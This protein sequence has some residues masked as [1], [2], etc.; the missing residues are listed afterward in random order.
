M[1]RFMKAK[2]A[3]REGFDKDKVYYTAHFIN[4]LIHLVYNDEDNSFNYVESGDVKEVDFI[5]SNVDA[6]VQGAKEVILGIVHLE[7]ENKDHVK[8]SIDKIMKCRFVKVKIIKTCTYDTISFDKNEEYN[9][10]NF[11][12][13]S[14]YLVYNKEI[15]IA[16]YIDQSI[17]LERNDHGEC[18]L[19]M[20]MSEAIKVLKMESFTDEVRHDERLQN[21]NLFRVKAESYLSLRSSVHPS[22]VEHVEE[23]DEFLAVATVDQPNTLML[24]PRKGL[25][26]FTQNLDLHTE[27]VCVSDLT[28]E[29]KSVVNYI[30]NNYIYYTEG[31]K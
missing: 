14:V 11:D 23:G 8:P 7:S 21:Y 5:A 12:D 3:N 20:N 1:C 19:D 26:F 28:D 9:A 16:V 13:I 10:V 2:I 30:V 31:G 6:T 15:D 27:R 22:W 25:I 24:Q 17:I 4:T 18:I 29:E